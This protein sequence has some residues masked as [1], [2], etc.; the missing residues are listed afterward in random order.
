[1]DILAL[2]LILTPALIG[3]ASLAGRRW[4][5]AISGWLVGLPFTSAPVTFFIAL[6]HGRGFAASVATGTLIGT[7]S[8]AVFCLAY[9]WTACRFS[10]PLALLA[11]SFGF[12][13]LTALLTVPALPLLLDLTLVVAALLLMLRLMPRPPV[14]PM[15][16]TPL[17]HW[18]LPAR[19]VVAT[20]L[21]LLLT[22]IAPSL[23][24]RLTGLIAP[25]PLY[26]GILTIFAHRLQGPAAA[27]QVLR[28]LLYGLF[29]FSAFFFVAA[30][31]LDR[32]SIA[33]AF[34]AAMVAALALQALSL[35]LVRSDSPD[36]KSRI[37]DR[38]WQRGGPTGPLAVL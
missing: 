21:V 12:A 32:V 4:G 7:I 34:G 28:G 16:A 1:V 24:S 20:G 11:G 3:I 29:G 22:G 8:Q 26:G 30:A 23:G 36:G 2:K 27:V 33:L 35:R 37:A 5:P 13:A 9:A 17:P 15:S 18:D 31:L 25:F 38:T 19:M 14:A 10:W 6:S